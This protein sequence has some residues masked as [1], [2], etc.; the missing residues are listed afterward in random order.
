MSIIYCILSESIFSII[1]TDTYN[2]GLETY[3]KMIPP[4]PK[5]IL[6]KISPD[7]VHSTDFTLNLNCQ[8]CEAQYIR[9]ATIS[10]PAPIGQYC[11][12]LRGP[13]AVNLR[14][15]WGGTLGFGGFGGNVGMLIF[16]GDLKMETPKNVCLYV[17]YVKYA[18]YIIIYKIFAI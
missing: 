2:I 10:N 13:T 16:W 7:S 1:Y 18:I 3:W 11:P 12:K 4:Q 6:H 17:L 9:I 8:R 15:L 5:K 14:I